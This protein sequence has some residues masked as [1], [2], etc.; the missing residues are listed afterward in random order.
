MKIKDAKMKEVKEDWS[1][2][3]NKVS[4]EQEVVVK[5]RKIAWERIE[6][7]KR[8]GADDQ[9]ENDGDLSEKNGEMRR[10]FHG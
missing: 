6:T 4:Q 1:R 8:D 2:G 7:K 9:C 5:V 3:S 10:Y